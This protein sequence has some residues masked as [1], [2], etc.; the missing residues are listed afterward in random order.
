MPITRTPI[1]DDD[2]SGQTGTVI[3][4]AWKQQFYDQIDAFM[5]PVADMG[6]VKA[7]PFNAANFAGGPGGT[8]TVAVGHVVANHYVRLNDLI[9]WIVDIRG[10][11]VAGA[12]GYLLLTPPVPV[13]PTTNSTP[14]AL[15][16]DGG[17]G[18]PARAAFAQAQVN[19]GIVVQ[20]TD[21]AAFAPGASWLIGTFMYLP[22]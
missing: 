12:P 7:V 10:G 6:E 2:G 17:P 8:W 11:A 13:G 4:N 19:T 9:V 18:S 5:L 1:I 15:Y 21:L 16:L 20:R 3:D 22:A 14:V